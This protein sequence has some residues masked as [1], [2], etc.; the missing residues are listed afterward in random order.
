VN[1]PDPIVSVPGII[2][3]TPEGKERI[4]TREIRFMKLS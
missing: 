1:P 3:L 4:L 2:R